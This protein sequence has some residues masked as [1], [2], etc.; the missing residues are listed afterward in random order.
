MI[1]DFEIVARQKC[2]PP[3]THKTGCYIAACV[4]DD[5]IIRAQCEGPVMI[6]EIV[7]FKGTFERKPV[8]GALFVCKDEVK[9][10]ECTISKASK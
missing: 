3:T 8:A 2:D 7:M 5:E 9:F 6:S 4:D 1:N 10:S